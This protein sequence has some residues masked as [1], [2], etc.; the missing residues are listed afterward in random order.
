MLVFCG[1]FLISRR[2]IHIKY[3]EVGHGHIFT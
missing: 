3:A 2:N 1:I